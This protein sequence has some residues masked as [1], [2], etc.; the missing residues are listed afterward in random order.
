MRSL[1]HIP[2]A[3]AA[4][5]LVAL[6]KG[7]GAHTLMHFLYRFGY[8]GLFL[9]SVV[10]SSF[11]PLPIPGVTDVMVVLYAA[12]HANLILLLA[13]T[14]AGSAL[15]GLFSHAVGQAGG[16]QFLEKHVPERILRRV[17]GWMEQHAILSVA[18]PAVLPPPMPL[19]AFVLAAG[20]AHMSRRKFMI[21]FTASRFARHAIFAW[22]GIRYGKQVLAF[23]NTFSAKWGATILITFWSIILVF[24]GVGIWKLVQTSRQVRGA[25]PKPPAAADSPEAC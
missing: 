7:G 15:G 20:A 10:D 17:T 1:W 23:W 11:V 25:S 3:S 8:I 14:T 12:N 6:A 5:V 21:A 18:L 13:I 24:T 9:V 19:S 4:A 2:V 22:L 16:K